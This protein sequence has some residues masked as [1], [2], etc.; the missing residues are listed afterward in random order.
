VQTLG[1]AKPLKKSV[2]FLK[3]EDHIPLP[4][5]LGCPIEAARLRN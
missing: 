5:A 4:V 3:R 2:G 1:R